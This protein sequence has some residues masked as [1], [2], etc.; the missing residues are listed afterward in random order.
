MVTHPE[1]ADG[2]DFLTHSTA[3]AGQTGEELALHDA[4]HVGPLD[5]ASSIGPW[6]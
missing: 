2:F 5:F 6:G 3:A 4:R 1:A